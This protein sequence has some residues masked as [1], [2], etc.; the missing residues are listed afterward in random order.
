MAS[1]PRP[2]VTLEQ[3]LEMEEKS[4]VTHEYWAGEVFEMEATSLRH[5]RIVSR[6]HARIFLRLEGGGCEVYTQKARVSTAA[7][8]RMYTYPDIVIVCGK[9]ETEPADPNGITNPKVLMEVL[10]PS[11]EDY[12]RG[13][14]AEIYRGIASLAEY[15]IVH[16]DT[17]Y[18]E[19]WIRESGAKWT[20]WDIRGIESVL[21][22]ESLGIEIPFREIYPVESH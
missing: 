16:Q 11:T 3:Y 2:I 18:I 9:V 14:K 15:V 1:L 20:M 17:P 4:E 8:T 7:A 10:S 19:H 5:E 6:L 21:R 13:K 12:D 22:L